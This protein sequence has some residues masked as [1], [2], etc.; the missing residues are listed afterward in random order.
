M[1]RIENEPPTF[2]RRHPRPVKKRLGAIGYRDEGTEVSFRDLKQ[3][4]QVCGL[5]EADGVDSDAFYDGTA[6][7]DAFVNR[8]RTVLR[9][10][11]KT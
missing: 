11:A 10:L 3:L 6:V 7:I 8:Y 2:F 1:I 9:R 4:R 5:T